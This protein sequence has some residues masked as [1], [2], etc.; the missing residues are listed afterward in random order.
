MPGARGHIPPSTH[1][2]PR[3]H[4]MPPR[5]AVPPAC[6]GLVASPLPSG[7]FRLPCCS[8]GPLAMP[9]LTPPRGA[10]VARASA[11]CRGWPFPQPWGRPG[12]PPATFSCLGSVSP[13][14]L[15]PSRPRA[16]GNPAT[17][18]HTGDPG[19]PQAE[20]SK[21]MEMDQWPGIPAGRHIQQ[22]RGRGGRWAQGPG[23]EGTAIGSEVSSRGRLDSATFSK[24]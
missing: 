24:N 12:T 16:E 5:N 21:Q 14:L 15:E 22:S 6:P 1:L 9:Q 19:G 20:S 10:K 4:T 23:G 13:C 17:C 2:F 18:G 7:F 8:R 11:P 3:P